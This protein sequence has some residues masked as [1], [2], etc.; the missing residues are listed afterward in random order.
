[1]KKILVIHQSS[2]LYGSDK[3][4]LYLFSKVN[5]TQYQFVVVLPSQGPLF[6]ALKKLNI[7]VY[8]IPVL[9]LHRKLFTFKNLLQFL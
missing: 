8:V 6:E 2:E 4:L 9:K 7:P 5:T 3:T 1:L